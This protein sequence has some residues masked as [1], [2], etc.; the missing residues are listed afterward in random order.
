MNSRFYRKS[1]IK[2]QEIDANSATNSDAET[3]A[4]PASENGS[5]C[6]GV[7]K[8]FDNS[9]GFGFLIRDGVDGD[10]FIH[11]RQVRYN[12]EP[13]EPRPHIELHE[14]QSVEFEVQHEQL[15]PKAYD[16]VVLE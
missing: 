1:M 15:G 16:V 8:W 12:R 10:V 4:D 2:E 7:V 9:K 5:R 3:V 14:G 6:H 13:G 11:W